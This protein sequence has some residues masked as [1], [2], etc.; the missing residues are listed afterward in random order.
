VTQNELSFPVPEHIPGR[1]KSS[2]YVF[3]AGDVFRLSVNTMNPYP[4]IWNSCQR[5]S[6]TAFCHG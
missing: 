5:E 4:G 3:F 1:E 6:L 2:S